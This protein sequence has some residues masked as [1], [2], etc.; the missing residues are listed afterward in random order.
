MS[1]ADLLRFSTRALRGHR[2][3]STLSLGGVAI[4]V[5]SVMLLTSL[6]E[7]ARRYITGE[8]AAL[9]SNLIIVVPGKTETEGEAP[10]FSET[11]A[12]SDG[13]RCGGAAAALAAHR[14]RGPDLA[15]HGNGRARR[16]ERDVTVI[17]TTAEF[18]KIRKIQVS[19]GRFLPEGEVDRSA[20]SASSAPRSSASCSSGEN[21]L[22]EILRIGEERFKVIGVNAAR[23]MSI[24]IDLDEVVDIPVSAALAPVRPPRPVPDLHRGARERVRS[25]RRR[26]TSCRS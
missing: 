2:L 13:R 1:A 25:A 9:G 8:F 22:G 3:R 24:G 18:Q 14:P 19:V 17:G 4:G 23:G 12:R 26:R 20:A 15:R 5:A 7:G 11:A 16:A 6:G 10:I 21:P